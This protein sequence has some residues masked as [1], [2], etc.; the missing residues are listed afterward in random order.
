M[1]SRRPWGWFIT[2]LKGKEY[3]V[4]ILCFKKGGAISHQRHYYRHE[5][6][7]FLTGGGEFLLN[8]TKTIKKSGF[9]AVVKEKD[10]H[11]FTATR[12]TYVLEVQTGICDETDI[13]RR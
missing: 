8:D 1:F 9:S 6:W 5:V 11:K 4:K 3:K 12:R 2:L 7:C 13:E 10:W